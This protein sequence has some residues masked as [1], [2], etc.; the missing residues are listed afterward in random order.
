[1]E[2]TEKGFGSLR[3]DVFCETRPQSPIGEYFLDC[4]P[5]TAKR[6]LRADGGRVP[7]ERRPPPRSRPT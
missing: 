1:M 6:E 7:V 4:L 2:I 3:S 5:G